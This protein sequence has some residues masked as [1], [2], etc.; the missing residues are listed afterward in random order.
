[1]PDKRHDRPQDGLTASPLAATAG[2]D[3]PDIYRNGVA[4]NFARIAA[5]AGL[6]MAFPLPGDGEIA[7]IFVP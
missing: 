5:I 6:V 1:M 7:P 2:F 4:E 3:I